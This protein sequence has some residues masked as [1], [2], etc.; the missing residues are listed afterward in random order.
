[1]KPWPGVTGKSILG[2]LSNKVLLR[3]LESEINPLLSDDPRAVL[4]HVL[5]SIMEEVVQTRCISIFLLEPDLMTTK[6][7]IALVQEMCVHLPEARE[8]KGLL[9]YGEESNLP[10]SGIN[11]PAES[12]VDSTYSCCLLLQITHKINNGVYSTLSQ[13]NSDFHLLYENCA[14][15]NGRSSK[16]AREALE[17]AKAVRKATQNY[18]KEI[19]DLK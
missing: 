19:P 16:F 13:F 18:I 5:S 1:M 3:R 8:Q 12:L 6:R 10:Q 4:N 17:M 11:E 7:L 15:Y 2:Y 9:Q 14:Y